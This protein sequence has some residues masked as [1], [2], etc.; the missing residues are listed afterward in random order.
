MRNRTTPDNIKTL[1]P[2]QIFV[3]GSNQGGKHLGGAAYQAM[4][5][6]GAV[7]GKANGLQGRSYAITTKDS[8]I[9]FTLPISEIKM[10]VD[11]FISHAIA[12]NHLTYLV[13]EIGCGLANLTPE[14]VAPLFER[15]VPVENI[16]LPSR[17][18]EVLNRKSHANT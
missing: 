9:Q 6:F 7:Y 5:E 17:F 10:Y 15:A 1:A 18:W 12:N 4:K 16:H 8:L 11:I 3:F 14:E 13:T 2:N